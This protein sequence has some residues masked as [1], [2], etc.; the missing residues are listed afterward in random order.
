[1][2][3]TAVSFSV[4]QVKI[5]KI[6]EFQVG[7][8]KSHKITENIDSLEIFLNESL[9]H[10]SQTNFHDKKELIRKRNEYSPSNVII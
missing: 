6:V 2:L 1:M 8:W 5:L 7:H 9:G 3:T 10:I 4:T